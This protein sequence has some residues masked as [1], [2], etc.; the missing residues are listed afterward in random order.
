MSN[1]KD[2][3]KKRKKKIKELLKEKQYDRIFELYGQR[4]YKIYVPEFYKE[5]DI[6]MLL[7]QGRFEDI[8]RKYGINIYNQY[9]HK[10]QA[11]DVLLETGSKPRS[12]LTKMKNIIL[13]KILPYSVSFLFAFSSVSS[14]VYKVSSIDEHNQNIKKKSDEINAYNKYIKKYAEQ[15]KS[16][17]LTHTQIFVKLINDMW[18]SIEG[19]K[20][21]EDELI[22]YYRLSL[23][24]EGIGVCRHFADDI[25]AKLN[26]I[27]PE[28]NARNLVVYFEDNIY[29]F[30]NVDERNILEHDET[31][32]E[33][34]ENISGESIKNVF[35]KLE[36]NHMV[37][38]V[39]IPNDEVTLII[40]STNPAIGVFKNGKIHMFSTPDG[41]SL[42]IATI[43]QVCFYGIDGITEINRD[44]LNSFF[45]CPYSLEELEETY[46]IDALNKDLDYVK[47]L[48]KK[49]NKFVEKIEINNDIKINDNINNNS[50]IDNNIFERY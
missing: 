41:K 5:E 22:G 46:G 23:L 12:F 38:A 14:A 43:G 47:N 19:Y 25:T 30:F 50:K 13:R 1:N 9:I 6:E 11:M 10:M 48:E 45:N 2:E 29:T 42:D 3:L 18:N 4:I 7:K 15:V 28:Y 44:L 24:E 36:G 17:N 49:S 8:Y 27:N 40:D 16:M 32:S 35:S 39:D 34:I 26:E 20:T 33:E 21:P 31:V 37:T